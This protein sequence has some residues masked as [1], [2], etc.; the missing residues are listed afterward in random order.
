[1]PPGELLTRWSVR[2]A[3]A[4]YVAAIFTLMAG[5][6]RPS[7]DRRARWFWTAGLAV[8]LVHVGCAFHYFHGWSHAAAWRDTA[9][10]TAELTGW[11]WGGGLWFNY[12]FAA[13]WACDVL[14]W[15]LGGLRD[16]RNRSAWIAWPIHAF[17]AFIAF[18]A[19]VVFESGPL[20][21]AGIAATVVLLALAWR[22][23]RD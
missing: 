2:L 17:L 11:D 10:Q 13:L 14:W 9:R 5:R 4:L 23:V 19:T 15:W 6:G 1:M 8:F 21:W 18:N 12:V 22:E 3:V 20:R 7:W 16:Y